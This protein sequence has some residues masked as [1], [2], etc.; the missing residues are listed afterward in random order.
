MSK[1]R[2]AYTVAFAIYFMVGTG[3]ILFFVYAA[4]A[5][6]EVR[7]FAATVARYSLYAFPP[8]VLLFLIA[9]SGKSSAPPRQLYRRRWIG[10]ASDRLHPREWKATLSELRHQA[11]DY[12]VQA[13]P[14]RLPDF[15]ARFNVVLF[16]AAG[17]GKTLSLRLLLQ[18]LVRNH[19]SGGIVARI[20]ISDPK[21]RT[22]DYNL[23]N[24]VVAMV[25]HHSERKE[26]LRDHNIY[27]L[28]P[29]D[30]RC[31]NPL[32]SDLVQEPKHAQALA[33]AWVRD[34]ATGGDGIYWR[35]AARV[36]LAAVMLVFSRLGKKWDLRDVLLAI[37]SPDV[38]KH[39]LGLVPETRGLAQV[40]LHLSERQAAYVCGTLVAYLREFEPL[41]AGWHRATGWEYARK[42]LDLRAWAKGDSPG[43]IYLGGDDDNEQLLGT[44]WSG[45]VARMLSLNMQYPNGETWYVLDE[46]GTLE[47]NR[48]PGERS[49]LATPLAQARQK[50]L[51]FALAY[52]SALQLEVN[53]GREQAQEILSH[54]RNVVV[55]NQGGAAA[56]EAA[57]KLFGEME[58]LHEVE[59]DSEQWG[60]GDY[61][62]QHTGSGTSTSRHYAQIPVVQPGDLQ[63]LPLCNEERGMTALLS[64]PEVGRF[65]A[66][67]GAENLAKQL[68]PH[69]ESCSTYS[70][71]SEPLELLPWGAED[72]A[73]L[74]LPPLGD[75]ACGIPEF[76][77]DDSERK[78]FD[79]LLRKYAPE[80]YVRL[81]SY[82]PFNDNEGDYE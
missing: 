66:R 63:D 65:R 27:I 20:V 41:A 72:Y 81:H 54:L 23:L 69:D 46:A 35:N 3:A 76:S 5:S 44:F 57:S 52:Q 40:F 24:S 58:V 67:M 8:M 75:D 21:S 36:V 25:L 78:S 38:L 45:L 2:I 1:L 26:D 68:L 7:E 74:G 59:N 60:R 64:V 11:R 31:S 53:Y 51:R 77:V 80:D 34:I 62:L 48:K 4:G 70:D 18:G 22:E 29:L 71:W 79:D 12:V 37:R 6:R 61:G 39:I 42:T 73:R 47:S 56:A 17:S 14:V 50:G 55:F 49:S 16:G 9:I 19:V 28:N 33:N 82:E 15:I 30:S 32:L 10:G 13:G 43:V